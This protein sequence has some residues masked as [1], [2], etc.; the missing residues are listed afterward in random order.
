MRAIFQ[1][2]TPYRNVDKSSEL[3]ANVSS[4]SRA[5]LGQLIIEITQGVNYRKQLGT[6][7]NS[8]TRGRRESL[9][10]EH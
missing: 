8:P 4:E 5:N 7:I 1:P 3:E 10:I 2:V 6:I 9:I